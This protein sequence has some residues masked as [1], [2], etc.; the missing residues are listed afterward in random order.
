MHAGEPFTPIRR[1]LWLQSCCRSVLSSLGI[2]F[3]VQG[4][5]PAAG[6]LVSNH[7]S[8]LDIL[9]Y[10]A[11]LPCVFV[12]KAEVARWPFFGFTARQSGTIFIDRG[13][14][15]STQ[16]VAQEIARRIAR[17]LTSPVPILVFPEGTSTDGAEVHR[18]H[19]GLFEPATAAGAPV[20]AAAVRYVLEGDV[21][22]RELCWYGDEGFLAH[23]WKALA[24]P[25]FMA[26]LRFSQPRIY[27]DRR[28]AAAA[29]H[30]ETTLLRGQQPGFP[31]L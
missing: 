20:T 3:R 30:A 26:E 31:T 2:R 13:K 4:V 25:G 16:T 10:G 6:L 11:A 8:Y 12:S 29:T 19:S 1:A 18:F 7:L 5:P 27:T 23:L 21:P 9:I 22:E 15:V 24:V 28:T 14:R 17:P